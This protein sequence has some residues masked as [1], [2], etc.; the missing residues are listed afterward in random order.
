MLGY[1]P[2][3]L[4]DSVD[5]WKTLTNPDD[6]SRFEAVIDDHIEHFWPLDFLARLRHREGGWRRIHFK[7]SSIR[8]E[9]GQPLRLILVCS[10]VTRRADAEDQHRSLAIALQA[11]GEGIYGLDPAGNITFINQA[12]AEMLG[13][14]TRELQ[15]RSE[16][17]IFHHS[18]VNEAPYP[19]QDCPILF[20]LKAGAKQTGAADHFWRK[21]KSPFPVEYVSVPIWEGAAVTGAVVT[22][23]DLTRQRGLESQLIHAHK[24]ESIGQLAAGV[25]HEINTP[26]QYI[27]DNL[28][29][30]KQ[31]FA[32][33]LGLL[34]TYDQVLAQATS[35][36]L[37]DA[38]PEALAQARQDA[39]LEYLL[40]A[41][42][43][44]LE[45]ASGGVT[46]VSSIVRALKSFSHPGGKDKQLADIN[47]ALENTVAIARNEWKY[48]AEVRT[49]LAADL[50]RVACFLGE[51]NQVFL[52]V[53]VNAAQAIAE[54]KERGESQKGE[55]FV[56]TRCADDCVEIRIKDSGP[57]IPEA[58]RHRIFDPF[59]TT[60]DVGKG[61]GQG[62]SVA[63]SIVTKKHGGAIEVESAS[64]DG[65][66]FLIRLPITT[67]EKETT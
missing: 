51:L 3:E 32:D 24:L 12:A 2:C 41:V 17:E 30:L 64:R 58:I 19:A 53:I 1:E 16:H 38:G 45:G 4:V 15:G 57:G 33:V 67:S 59:F 28:H 9:S 48:V 65:T 27:G 61:S 5:L 36:G 46:A 37:P 18:R 8:D 55:I 44:A 11:A 49:E 66:T 6:L 14:S 25:A 60:K 21:D 56:Q 63:R 13:W 34:G 29:F 50:P 10:D 52:N 39:D 47:A 40:T 42:P 20:T 54:D 31:A 35:T 62:L 7:G 26:M 43:T 22:F 23:R